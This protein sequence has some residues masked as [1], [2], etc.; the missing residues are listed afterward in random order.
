MIP[1]KANPVLLCATGGVYQQWVGSGNYGAEN[2][3]FRNFGSVV[4]APATDSLSESPFAYP[5]QGI[6]TYT[7]RSGRT[8]NTVT[9]NGRVFYQR[10]T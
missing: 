8:W 4:G 3:R 6:R 5:V 7:D 1:S 2:S 10:A 9:V